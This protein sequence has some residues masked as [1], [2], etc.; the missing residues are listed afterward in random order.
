MQALPAECA[1]RS[2][3]EKKDCELLDKARHLI[4]TQNYRKAIEELE[5][6]RLRSVDYYLLLAEA[7]EGIGNTE[8]AEVYLEEARFLD[9]ELRSMERLRRGIGFASLKDFKSAEKELLE[10]VRLNPFGSS[11]YQELYKLYKKVGN[12][13]GMIRTL[14][15]MLLLNPFSTSTHLE[16]ARLLRAKGRHLKAVRLLRSALERLDSPE[17]HF[18]LGKLYAEAGY[19]EH[20]KESLFDA[21]LRSP[22]NVEYRQKLIDVLTESGDYATALEVAFATL[23]IYPGSVYLLQS[24]AGI[25]SA[26]GMDELAEHYHRRAVSVSTGFMREEALRGLIDFL[27]ERGMYDQ[28]E[29]LLKE[30]IET[31][32][33][34]WFVVDAFFELS[35]I[36]A[37]QERHAEIAVLG[38]KVLKNPELSGDEFCEVAEVVADA[39]YSEG[40]LEKALSLYRKILARGATGKVAKRSYTRISEIE[41]I[42]SLERML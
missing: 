10:S 41:E 30:V 17:L 20:A 33:N 35:A 27:L 36:L 28:A 32:S 19:L 8:K 34:L 23:S 5:K 38:E 2:F 22:L 13:D 24:I 11:A 6:C 37:D 9:T 1:V 21:C 31:S 12:Y 14:E 18:E 25:Y 15:V 40:N 16:L 3:R 26:M 39:L 4:R 42:L 7:Y 29:E